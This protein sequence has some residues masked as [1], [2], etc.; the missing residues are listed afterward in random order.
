MCLQVSYYILLVLSLYNITSI[1]LQILRRGKNHAQ[2]NLQGAIFE[3]S[4]IASMKVI[5]AHH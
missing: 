4:N 1:H 3:N 2:G 5:K